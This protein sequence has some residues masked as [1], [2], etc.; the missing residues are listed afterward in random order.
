MRLFIPVVGTRLLLQTQITV[1]LKNKEQNTRFIEALGGSDDEYVSLTLPRGTLLT[2]DRVYIRQGESPEF[3]SLTFK[4][5]ANEKAGIPQGRFYLHVDVVNTLEVEVV[6]GKPVPK[7]LTPRSLMA[8]FFARCSTQE[9]LSD[10]PFSLLMEQM[11]ACPTVLQGVVQVDV[12]SELAILEQCVTENAASLGKDGFDARVERMRSV[13]GKRH[14]QPIDEAMGN[15]RD[16]TALIHTLHQNDCYGD[17]YQFRTFRF[18][19]EP[20]LWVSAIE[21]RQSI[22]AL[23]AAE[24]AYMSL[25]A[26]F[27]AS[28]GQ[29][30]HSV[31]T[32]AW[33]ILQGRLCNPLGNENFGLFYRK[34]NYSPKPPIVD[35]QKKQAVIPFDAFVDNR[36]TRTKNEDHGPQFFYL[37][38]DGRRV[39][40]GEL[41][42]LM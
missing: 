34:H 10:L 26:L 17:L 7:S 3:N 9:R 18:H 20:V 22:K 14:W 19:D 28:E 33:P 41:R 36:L 42:K 32:L 11:N 38:E 37:L 13:L 27:F 12:K 35:Q 31:R 5:K 30:V 40:T 4:V 15:I 24:T 29:S 8:A 23:L 39:T 21:D 2:V 25:F 1:S 16:Q 6:Q